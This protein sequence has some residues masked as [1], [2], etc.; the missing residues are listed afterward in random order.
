MWG[1]SLQQREGRWAWARARGPRV[2]WRLQK[3]GGGT[4]KGWCGGEQAAGG[5]ASEM[6]LNAP[7]ARQ[8]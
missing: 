3:P 4:A 5:E 1:V 2:L 6:L 7:R 8:S